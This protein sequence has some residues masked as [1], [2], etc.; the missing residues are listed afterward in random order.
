MYGP[1]SARAYEGAGAA[2]ASRPHVIPIHPAT[3]RRVLELYDRAHLQRN[4]TV[5][6]FGCGSGR[7]GLALIDY[8][9]AGGYFGFDA[10]QFSIRCFL[11]LELGVLRPNLQNKRPSIFHETHWN[12]SRVL[13]R[14]APK[15]VDAVLFASVLKAGVFNS[16]VRR[17]IL[18][19]CTDVLAPGGAI[20]VWCDCDDNLQHSARAI[21]LEMKGMMKEHGCIFKKGPLR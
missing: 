15:S 12:L 14:A 3:T 9:D 19:A 17:G 1:E 10:D 8:L 20:Y 7:N 2:N 16:E 11:Q 21:G 18:Q 13:H 4:A 5:L 6:D